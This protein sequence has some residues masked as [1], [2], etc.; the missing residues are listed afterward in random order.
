MSGFSSPPGM[1]QAAVEALIPQPATSAPLPCKRTARRAR[2]VPNIF[3]T[4]AQTA[5]VNIM[6]RAPS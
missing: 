2:A 1:T 5:W 4:Q 3:T 6:S